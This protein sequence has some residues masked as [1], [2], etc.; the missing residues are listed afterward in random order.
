MAKKKKQQLNKNAK[1]ALVCSLSAAVIVAGYILL[2]LIAG[3][4]DFIGKT[5]INGVDVSGMTKQEAITALEQ[6]YKTDDKGS[7]NLSVNND[8]T[9]TVKTKDL[10]VFDATQGVEN[11]YNDMHSSF[12]RQ[13]FLYFMGG[14]YIAP[15]TLKDQ[16]ALEKE[17]LTSKVLDY[18]TC[19]LTQ[20]KILDKHVE[21]TKGK[22]GVTVSVES[23]V[24]DINKALTDYK[25][26]DTIVC[27]LQTSGEYSKEM[28]RVY[29]AIK[30]EGTN[31]TLDKNNNYAIIPS[32][33]G[34]AY[35][36]EEAKTAFSNIEAGQTI[37]VSA[38]ITQPKVTTADL[39]KN[40]FK[41]VLGSYTTYVS[42]TDV[43]RNNVRLAGNKCNEVILLPGEEFSYNGV[44]GERTIANGFG[45]AAA[46]VNGLT[47]NEV[48]GGVCQPSSTLYNAVM[49]AN[50]QVTERSPHSYV[51]AYV[52][53]GRDA[54]VSWG[55]PDFKFKNTSDY[56]IKVTSVYKDHNLTMQIHGT[57]V[58][59]ITVKITSEQLSTKPYSTITREDKNLEVGKTR[60]EVSGYTGATAQ[61]YRYVYKNGVLISSGKE[62][63]SSYKKRD[64]IVYK[65]TKPV[66]VPTTPATPSTPEG[67]NTSTP[68][69]GGENTGA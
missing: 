49:L 2:C 60:V 65:G 41:H 20:Y 19:V 37:K 55:G 68:A 9:Y 27:T 12:L 44:V 58:D 33:V 3:G 24:A 61:S 30:G 22:E 4:N 21:F 43:R 56:P 38:T 63:Y 42:G 46:Y 67:N 45:A 13:G 64:Q 31:A 28:E 40:L 11:V 36:V 50:L 8:K 35:N 59:N 29:N 18:D 15:V 10:L 14:E 16:S 25:L 17:I 32:Q 51:S 69:S 62:A 6:Q 66:P 52:P 23:V 53:I 57:N 26:T 5:I 34:V 48:G 7:L 39:Q 47:V 1:I 54:A